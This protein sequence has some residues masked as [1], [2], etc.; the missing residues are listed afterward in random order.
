MIAVHMARKDPIYHTT[1]LVVTC[2]SIA[3]HWGGPRNREL[4]T[5]DRVTAHACFGLCAYSHLYE[6]PSFFGAICVVLVLLL[7]IYENSM[8]KDWERV[9]MV[10]HIV[11]LAGI[12][13]ALENRN[14]Y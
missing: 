6:Y 2:V 4:A 14:I 13:A 10:L 1:L 11:A 5:M 3:R 12:I 7:W 8:E 9:H